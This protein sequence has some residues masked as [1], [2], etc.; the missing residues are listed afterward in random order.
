MMMNAGSQGRLPNI[1]E[2][3]FKVEVALSHIIRLGSGL[4]PLR[5]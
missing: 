4:H 2:E 3:G 5:Q 1:A